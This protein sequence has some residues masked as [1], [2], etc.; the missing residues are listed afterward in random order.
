[1]EGLERD[2]AKVGLIDS[3]GLP[4]PTFSSQTAFGPLPEGVAYQDVLQQN[5]WQLDKETR[6]FTKIVDGVK[7]QATNR[8]VIDLLP[9]DTLP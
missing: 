1:M 3:D 5:G 8:F 9:L 6:F 4:T 7:Y 2:K